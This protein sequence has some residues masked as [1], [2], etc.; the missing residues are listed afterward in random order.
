MN[1][2]KRFVFLAIFL[3]LLTA[4]AN[5]SAETV[6][7]AEMNT[8]IPLPTLTPQPLSEC[9]AV[10]AVPTP[11]ADDDSL[12]PP[13]DAADRV[14]GQADASVTF[15]VYCD[16]QS[17]GCAT[18]M[19][20]LLTLHEEFP[21]DVRVVYRD[22][23]QLENPGHELSGLAAQAVHAAA[24]QGGDWDLQSLLL[25]DQAEWGVLTESAFVAWVADQAST[26]GMDGA[27]LTADLQSDAFA[28]LPEETYQDA[29][30]I[31]IPATPFLLFNGQIYYTLMDLAS[32][33]QV[34]QLTILGERQYTS[35]PPTVIDLQK[36]YLAY[37]ETEY[38]EIVVQFYARQAPVTVNNFVF[39]AQEG[40]YDGI[41]FHRVVPGFVAQT[42]D[43]SG[44]GQGAPGYFFA[45]EIVENLKFDQPGVVGMANLG[46]DTNGSQFF[47]TYAAAPSL[48]GNYT[49]F[50]QVIQGMDVLEKLTPRD[51]QF[52]GE[53]LPAGDLLLRVRIEER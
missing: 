15:T 4:C 12:F 34:T 42:G 48:N 27:Q 18:I 28:D 29:L 30:A 31:G 1:R 53:A 35:C 47:I 38:G 26:L 2:S 10:N 14:L 43:P 44:T 39:L 22:Y 23:P 5:T 46:V 25:A 16:L 21:A 24:L 6:P 19:D 32:L 37:L 52:A 20:S 50:G 11:S 13:V 49:V 45:N 41:T 40:W 7:A 9:F 3:F 8:P 33:R 51:Q 17:S 36:E